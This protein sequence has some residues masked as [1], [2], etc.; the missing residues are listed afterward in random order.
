MGKSGGR[1]GLNEPHCPAGARC[2]RPC[3]AQC[4][5]VLPPFTCRSWHPPGGTGEAPVRA[6]FRDLC[7]P[8]CQESMKPGPQRP[9]CHSPGPK[10]PVLHSRVRGKKRKISP[11]LVKIVKFQFITARVLTITECVPLGNLPPGI[12]TDLLP[13]LSTSSFCCCSQDQPPNHLISGSPFRIHANGRLSFSTPLL[14]CHPQVS[15]TGWH[16]PSVV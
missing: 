5:L 14:L 12:V 16:Q 6:T 10:C 3:S 4:P 2:V 8:A 13:V 7:P 11:C 9:S 1:A 15:G